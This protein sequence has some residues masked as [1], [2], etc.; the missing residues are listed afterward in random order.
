[1]ND[2]YWI[3]TGADQKG[4]YTLT[5]L[6]S[7]WRAGAITADALYCQEG[8]EQWEPISLISD[9]LDEQRATP[10]SDL[11]GPQ[12]ATPAPAPI[13][14]ADSSCVPS[15]PSQPFKNP[16]AAA[17]LSLFVPGLGQIY[18][19]QILMGIILFPLVMGLYFIPPITVGYLLESFVVESSPAEASLEIIPFCWLAMLLGLVLNIRLVYY[20]YSHAT[21]LNARISAPR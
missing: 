17:V 10:A 18:N 20:A 21:K 7:M 1:M 6:Q 5:Q 11:P 12:Q 15:Q 13:P 4:P 8:F 3:L 2:H 16:G 9:L 19:G 14:V